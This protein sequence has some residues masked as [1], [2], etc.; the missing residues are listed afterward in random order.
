MLEPRGAEDPDRFELP[1]A[2]NRDDEV[3]ERQAAFWSFV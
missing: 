1:M 2:A 3:I